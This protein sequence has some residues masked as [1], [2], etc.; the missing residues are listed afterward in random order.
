MSDGIMLTNEEAE[1][2]LDWLEL[3]FIDTVRTDT[4]VDSM[5]WLRNMTRIWEKCKGVGESVYYADGKVYAVEGEG[6]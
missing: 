2:L 6:E 3:H 5:E 1:S 4:D